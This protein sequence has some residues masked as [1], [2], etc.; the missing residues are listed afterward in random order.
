MFAHLGNSSVHF[1]RGCSQ[2]KVTRCQMYDLGAGGVKVGPSGRSGEVGR[3]PRSGAAYDH[4]S[5]QTH[6]IEVT[7]NHIHDF[8]Q[9]GISVG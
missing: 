6:H 3:D 1:W 5:E 7:D 9:T 8:R 4:P 2:S